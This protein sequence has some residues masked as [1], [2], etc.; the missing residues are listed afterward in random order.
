MFKDALDCGVDFI[1]DT[2]LL[3]FKVDK[4]DHDCASTLLNVL[5]TNT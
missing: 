4:F 1:F 3:G 2:G 5:P